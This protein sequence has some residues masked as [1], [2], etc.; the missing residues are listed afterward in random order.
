M[1]VD[2]RIFLNGAGAIL[3]CTLGRVGIAEAEAARDGRTP[4]T[5]QEWGEIIRGGTTGTLRS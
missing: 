1:G 4:I 2:R 5:K 3:G